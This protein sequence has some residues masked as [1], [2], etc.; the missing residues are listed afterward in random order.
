MSD[1]EVDLN[2]FRSLLLHFLEAKLWV[3][4]KD[5]VTE[6]QRDTYYSLL[7]VAA[8]DC[9]LY[10]DD[11]LIPAHEQ[12]CYMLPPGQSWYVANY[13]GESVSMYQLKFK[14]IH[15]ETATSYTDPISPVHYN[16]RLFPYMRA[17]KLFEQLTANT[18]C[19]S[20]Q[21]G[22]GTGEI[23]RAGSSM[24]WFRR[25]QQFMEL[26]GMLIEHNSAGGE[27]SGSLTSAER[28]IRYIEE[29]YRLPLNM[30]QLAEEAGAT[31]GQY[32]TMIKQLTGS[33]PLD[34]LHGI[35]I[36]LAKERLVATDEPLREVAHGV[37]YEDE[38]YFNRRFRQIVGIAPRQYAQ[39][40]RGS[41][42]ITDDAGREVRIP[43]KPRRILYY[44]E[45]IGDLLALGIRP[46]ASNLYG[47][48][49]SWL[50]E[51]DGGLDGIE[52][53]GIPLR[54][55]KA[56]RL[57]PDLIVLSNM[58][59]RIYNEISSIAPTIVYDSHN[60][61]VE[62]IE[63]LGNWL[64]KGMIA[65]KVIEKYKLQLEQARK[66]IQGFRSQNETVSVFLCHRGRKWFVMGGLGLSELLHSIDRTILSE[67]VQEIVAAG[68]AYRM[69]DRQDMTRYA[70]DVVIVPMPN[71]ASSREA[72]EQLLQS[73]LWQRIPAVQRGRSYVV[74][75]TKWNLYDA[76]SRMR[77][78]ERILENQ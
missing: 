23:A 8:G 52:D 35:R 68:E 18:D 21:G 20:G 54:L 37:G 69:I 28:S 46:I 24:A 10:A 57:E 59:E 76:I 11:R 6:D 66:V 5:Q 65:S 73:E 12:S 62:R 49:D 44:G 40:M 60:S 30:K 1:E 48:E 16:W 55:G 43:V 39:R 75:E 58:D 25:R 34:Y 50:T 53:I 64:D 32:A 15:V 51:E 63:R 7:L 71:N 38:Y 36:K 61:L 56:K 77:Q 13:S 72:T 17:I 78:L 4:Q 14:F 67:P 29:H 22:K 3:L 19:E 45:V 41:K 27:A 42:L 31:P 74:E 26:V 70:G 9:S 33:S 2:I 47:L